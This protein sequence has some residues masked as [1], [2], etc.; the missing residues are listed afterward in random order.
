MEPVGMLPPEAEATVALKVIE[1]FNAG[2]SE[3]AAS[4]VVVAVGVTGGAAVRGFP[5]PP[6]PPSIKPEARNRTS[7]PR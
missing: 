4:V 6:H 3:E 1:L 5:A 7:A 2:A